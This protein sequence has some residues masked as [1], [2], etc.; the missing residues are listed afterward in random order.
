MRLRSTSTL[1]MIIIITLTL[2]Y[3]LSIDRASCTE[4]L[5]VTINRT[6]DLRTNYALTEDEITILQGKLS[7]LTYYVFK[8]YRSKIYNIKAVD[9]NGNEI[10]YDI[11]NEE[12]Q[13]CI[14]F[15]LKQSQTPYKFK[16]KIYWIKG[17]V[18]FI[19]FLRI[20]LPLYPTISIPVE[21]FQATVLL[22]PETESITKI[23]PNA[24][25]QLN[26]R[27]M[28]KFN[29]TTLDPMSSEDLIVDFT[30]EVQSII[31]RSV[32]RE[33][34]PN[35][36]IQVKETIIFENIGATDVTK[37]K[38]VNFTLPPQAIVKSVED[39]FGQLTYKAY[40]ENDYITLNVKP[41]V[42]IKEGWKYRV[43]IKYELPSNQWLTGN[44]EKQ[45]T[46]PIKQYHDLPIDIFKVIIYIPSGS[47]LISTSGTQP[48]LKS[49]NKIVYQGEKVIGD[50]SIQE[51]SIT[52]TSPPTTFTIPTNIIIGI[53]TGAIIG[54]AVFIKR[55]IIKPKR[56]VKV[57]ESEIAIKV[58]E[59]DDAIREKI[60]I[61]TNLRELEETL[62]KKKISRKVHKVRVKELRDELRKTN[63]KIN[64]LKNELKSKNM[65]IRA[66][67]EEID[68]IERQLTNLIM[69]AIQNERQYMLKRLSRSAFEENKRNLEKNIRKTRLKLESKMAELTEIVT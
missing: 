54:A 10:P 51:A 49:E 56:K 17:F 27:W 28:A 14:K 1:I 6:I 18:S 34:H 2:N 67:I 15:T 53:I 31:G 41:R 13:T 21:E 57:I 20:K 33:I 69:E 29:K 35:S 5:K 45:L 38:G 50:I 52:Y 46:I 3:S 43:F 64:T 4:E 65:K 59:L 11:I 25:T 42:N 63:M 60:G 48:T 9:E 7:N 55:Y 12:N 22:P 19:A 66:I 62:R 23:S 47:K 32:T 37:K 36:K 30:G 58:D 68:E 24:T 61:L 16:V 26:G 39:D 44:G 8:P 40:E